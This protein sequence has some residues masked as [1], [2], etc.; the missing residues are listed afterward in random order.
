M[1][2]GVVIEEKMRKSEILCGRRFQ[3]RRNGRVL[4][5]PTR[6]LFY[7]LWNTPRPPWGSGTPTTPPTHNNTESSETIQREP[8]IPRENA[9][10]T[11]NGRKRKPAR[12]ICLTGPPPSPPSL[13]FRNIHFPVLPLQLIHPCIPL[14]VG[15]GGITCGTAYLAEVDRAFLLVFMVSSALPERACRNSLGTGILMVLSSQRRDKQQCQSG[16]G[17]G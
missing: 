7:Y 16:G 13:P 8:K 17:D 10:N 1:D 11:A 3:E 2:W 5:R 12:H 4:L 14:G 6:C 15:K 9:E